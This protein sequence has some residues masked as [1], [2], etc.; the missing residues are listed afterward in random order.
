MRNPN[1][2]PEFRPDLRLQVQIGTGFDNY[3]EHLRD[4]LPTLS[5]HQIEGL[6]T[7]IRAH[8]TARFRKSK[9][10]KYGSLNRGFTDGQLK[11]FFMAMD[12]PKHKLLF[13]Y[14]AYLGLR[15][16]E[17]VKVNIKD[18][19]FDTREIKI[20]SE[21]TKR[22]DVLIIPLY[23]FQQTAMFV[24]LNKVEID[25][26]QGYLFYKN[27]DRS[28]RKEPYLESNYVRK[29]FRDYT[30]MAGLDE[31]YDQSKEPE[32]KRPRS[33]HLLSTHSLR[34]YAITRFAKGCNGNLVLT[35]RFAR[36]HEP[37]TTMTYIAKDKDELYEQ[38]DRVF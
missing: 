14:M 34:H 26:A 15:I 11:S 5:K 32:G 18:I 33:L 31:V 3:S 4:V 21:K 6:T 2:I 17:V 12:N 22:L 29:V 1:I 35:S 38:I 27:A 16:G 28:L 20:R 30:A 7:D 19:N 9:I 10:P 13:S 37:N 23:L 24:G 36:H 8:F 25:N